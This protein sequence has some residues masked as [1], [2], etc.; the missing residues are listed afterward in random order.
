MIKI[1]TRSGDLIIQGTTK[2][3]KS[4]VE[5]AVLKNISLKDANLRGA[6]L[7]GTDLSGANL[8]G[9]DLSDACL[10]FA[11]L[12]DVD[13]RGA[14]L[15]FANLGGAD[16]RGADLRCTYL[17][18]ANLSDADLRGADL[19]DTYLGGANLK[20]VD[21]RGTNLKSTHMPLKYK[22]AKIFKYFLLLG[23]IGLFLLVLTHSNVNAALKKNEA[24]YQE[25]LCNDL[26]GIIEYRLPDRSRVDCLTFEYAIEVDFDKK[27]YECAAQALYYA[28]MTNRKPACA[29][30]TDK[31]ESTQINKLEVLAKAYNIKIIYID[32]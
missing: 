14:N 6:D 23:V 27:P 2:D 18:G 19:R 13:L 8:R 26:N 1:N 28:I 9:A 4:L 5:Y 24:Y 15:G 22:I 29:F 32:K 12:K 30:I 20:D 21:L 7:E 11:N 31:K 25:I 16:L 3:L 17:G 10:I